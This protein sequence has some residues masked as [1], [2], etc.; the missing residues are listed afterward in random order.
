MLLWIVLVYIVIINDGP[1]G[2]ILLLAILHRV[3][4]YEIHVSWYFVIF[5]RECDIRVLR[6]SVQ[7]QSDYHSQAGNSRQPGF[8]GCQP[9][10]WIDLPD[11]V[12]LAESLYIFCQRLRTCLFTKSFF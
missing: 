4:I 8:P 11:D 3:D 12:T 1:L 2:Y 5:I 7:S 6:T 10:T 9:R